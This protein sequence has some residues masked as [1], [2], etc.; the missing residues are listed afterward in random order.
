M[1]HSVLVASVLSI[2]LQIF[3]SSQAIVVSAGIPCRIMPTADELSGLHATDRRIWICRTAEALTHRGISV[4][5]FWFQRPRRAYTSV[6]AEYSQTL[7]LTLVKIGMGT[8]TDVM[9]YSI[10]LY[11]L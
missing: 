9:P 8:I 2:L 10:A 5:V 6:I 4:V 3:A 11:G 7:E 1:T